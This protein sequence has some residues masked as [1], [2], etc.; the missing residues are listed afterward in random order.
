MS[1]ADENVFPET[2]YQY[3]AD[4]VQLHEVPVDAAGV[5]L[6]EAGYQPNHIQPGVPHGRVQHAPRGLHHTFLRT[7]KLSLKQGTC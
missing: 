3:D 2:S 1:R 7:D 6:K 5:G 4:A